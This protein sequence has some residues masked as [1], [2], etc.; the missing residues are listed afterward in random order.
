DLC[1]FEHGRFPGTEVPT[2]DQWEHFGVRHRMEECNGV[3]YARGLVR[4]SANLAADGLRY[5]DRRSQK[6]QQID[7]PCSGEDD[8]RRPVD[9]D[10]IR[11]RATLPRDPQSR[12]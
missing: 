4:V 9:D 8:Q 5:V 1:P 10:S 12:S 2:P 7:P 3:E 11:H 6:A